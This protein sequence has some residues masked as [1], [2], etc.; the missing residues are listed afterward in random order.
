MEGNA[1]GENL[2]PLILF[3]GKNLWDSWM[4][5]T[6]E[7]YPVIPYTVTENGWLEAITLQETLAL[8]GGQ[9]LIY[10]GTAVTL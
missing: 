10:E 9:M 2:L 5:R 8:Q 7:D 4:A 6:G 3:N 1:A